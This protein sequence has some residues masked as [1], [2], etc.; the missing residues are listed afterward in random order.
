M[1]RYFKNIPFVSFFAFCCLSFSACA[2]TPIQVYSGNPHYFLFRGNPTILVG[3]TGDYMMSYFSNKDYVSFLNKLRAQDL[4]VVRLFT[5]AAWIWNDEP[6]SGDLAHYITPWVRVGSK[7]DL[8][9]W[10][11]AWFSRLKDYVA[12]ASSRGIVVEIV[13]FTQTYNSTVWQSTPLYAA[14]NVQGVGNISW[15]RF[16]S[17]DDQALVG[18]QDALAR[19]IVQELNGYDNVYYE[20]VNEPGA[21]TQWISHMLSTV[22]TA[23]ASLPNKHLIGL[24]DP[25]TFQSP[26]I[27]VHNAHYTYGG[28]WLGAFEMLDEYYSLNE[29]L[30]FNESDV[31]LKFAVPSQGRVEAWE[32]LVGGG[33]AY[34][35][36]NWDWNTPGGDEYRGYLKNLKDF[37]ASFDISKVSKDTSVIQEGV[38]GGGK[39]ARA[40]SEPGRQYAIYLHHSDPNDGGARSRYILRPGNYQANLL[41][42]L[43]AGSYRADW[44]SPSTGVPSQ[45]VSFSHGGGGKTLSSPEYSV[46]IA[47]RI[48][49]SAPPSFFA[50]ISTRFGSWMLSILSLK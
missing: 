31:V 27:R 34:N 11:D 47:L 42:D 23:E 6:N 41:L 14:N 36:L 37:L 26:D 48:L 22:L 45:T 39:Y 2:T 21:T 13:L 33:A 5:Y 46:D 50:A 30:A 25:T 35:G 8:S 49:G 12:Q 3:A 20:L 28:W 18:Y 16:N 19:K 4:N 32:F 10:N 9:Q 29:P 43:P 44:V 38:P 1:T 17:M 40:I 7:W 24:Q 15:D